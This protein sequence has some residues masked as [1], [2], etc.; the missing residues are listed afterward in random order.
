M[1]GDELTITLTWTDDVLEILSTLEG[2]TLA[3]DQ[4]GSSYEVKDLGEARLILGIRIDRNQ[5]G[6]RVWS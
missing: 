2:E 6:V 5:N 3:K 1:D 4:L